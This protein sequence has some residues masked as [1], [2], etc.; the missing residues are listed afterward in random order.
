[1][2]AIANQGRSP[3]Q[4]RAAASL[5]LP[6]V[7]KLARGDEYGFCP[8]EIRRKIDASFREGAC[9]EHDRPDPA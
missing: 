4:H 6:P 1:V 2:T 5:P 9:R 7:A 8:D 3:H